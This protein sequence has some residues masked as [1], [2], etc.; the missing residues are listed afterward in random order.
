MNLGTD[1]GVASTRSSRRNSTTH[2]HRPHPVICVYTEQSGRA[3]A[4]ARS[5]RFL[6]L[7]V[8]RRHHGTNHGTAAISPKID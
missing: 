8:S 6:L 4:R 1:E 7:D 3:I 2:T 5:V